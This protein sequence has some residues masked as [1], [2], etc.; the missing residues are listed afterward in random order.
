MGIMVEGACNYIQ[1]LNNTVHN[2]YTT[3]EKQGGGAQR[4]RRLR[5]VRLYSGQSF[6]Y[7]R[8]H[9]LRT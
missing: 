2:I 7:L 4:S 3:A 5:N 9:S 8:Q 6:D 1:L